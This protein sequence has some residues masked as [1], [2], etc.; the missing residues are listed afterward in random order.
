MNY[1]NNSTVLLVTHRPSALRW[2]DRVIYLNDGRLVAFE[3]HDKLVE[4]K[5]A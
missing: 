1:A 5:E 3:K 2:V 4:A